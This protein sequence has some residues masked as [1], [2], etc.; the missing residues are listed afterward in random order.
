MRPI[1]KLSDLH[2][3]NVGVPQKHMEAFKKKLISELLSRSP[4]EKLLC[5]N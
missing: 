5:V 2:S 3:L 1:Q 4:S